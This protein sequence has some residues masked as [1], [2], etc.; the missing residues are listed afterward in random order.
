V[1]VTE[2]CDSHGDARQSPRRVTTTDNSPAVSEEDGRSV[3]RRGSDNDRAVVAAEAER[4][5]D[6]RA[7]RPLTGRAYDE[8]DRRQ[9]RVGV[10]EARSRRD[11]A[12]EH[13]LQHGDRL[14]G[15]RA[16]E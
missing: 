11:R 5:A 6:R 15:T 8:I 7:G 14:D 16:A 3:G 2:T 13:R 9:L 4:V 10:L 12:V 1:T